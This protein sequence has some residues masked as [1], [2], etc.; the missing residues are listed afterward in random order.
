VRVTQDIKKRD[1]R[2][3]TN[4][5]ISMI[6]GERKRGTPY[7]TVHYLGTFEAATLAEVG[8]CHLEAGRVKRTY[9][10][11][12]MLILLSQLSLPFPYLGTGATILN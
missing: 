11:E 9:R 2:G 12:C 8:H 1:G 4:S 7:S 10:Q 5:I 6:F 3:I